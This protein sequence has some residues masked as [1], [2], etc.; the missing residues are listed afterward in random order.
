M[1]ETNDTKTVDFDELRKNK[2]FIATSSVNG[3]VS[4]GYFKSMIKTVF[5][6]NHHKIQVDIVTI[7]MDGSLSRTKN[8]FLSAFL[9]SNCTHLIFI[10][11]G[12]EFKPEDLL[13]LL[14]SN[15]DLIVGA[16]PRKGINWDKLRKFVSSNPSCLNSELVSCGIDCD[17][18]FKFDKETKS[19][20]PDDGLLE[21]EYT[22]SGFMCIRRE[23]VESMIL[24]YPELEYHINS[25]CG[26]LRPPLKMY[27]LFDSILFI[28]EKKYLNED[29]SFCERWTSKGGKIFIDPNISVKLHNNIGMQTSALVSY[30]N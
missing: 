3:Q 30:F 1:T 2:V 5:F 17:F 25:D 10:D 28:D 13:R 24:N 26:L 8:T 29:Y 6:L 15:K 16:V 7:P 19:L 20:I 22:N 27:S 9:N 12:I 23:A 11:S 14:V 21:I 18:V 4:D